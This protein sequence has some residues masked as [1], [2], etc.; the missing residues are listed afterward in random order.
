MTA[1]TRRSNGHPSVK[2]GIARLLKGCSRS[3]H[4]VLDKLGDAKRLLNFLRGRLEFRPRADDVFVATYPRSGTT[5]MQMILYQL[6]TD[7]KMDFTHISQVCPW[8]ERSLALG[9]M[10]AQDFE[11][12][13][14]PRI[15]KTHL[16]YRWLPKGCRYIYITRDGMD[17]AVSYYHLYRSHLGFEGS[18]SDFFDRFMKGKLQYKSWFKHVA[19]WQAQSGNPRVLFVRYGDMLSSLKNVVAEV[20][21][22]CGLE[23]SEEKIDRVLRR[24]VFEY[25]KKH[26]SKFDHATRVLLDRG[27]RP[28]SFIRKGNNGDGSGCLTERHRDAFRREL[29]KTG[30]DPTIELDLA[31][32][33]K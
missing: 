12:L 26:E 8:F 22:F 2:N 18:F 30:K 6:T 21:E 27:V 33:L 23:V 13:R 1:V 9:T 14:S 31:E 10:E 19:G 32:F 3:V 17:V 4:H 7:G 20:I 11:S 25:M 5:W 29:E 16:P 28:S 24:C 15:F